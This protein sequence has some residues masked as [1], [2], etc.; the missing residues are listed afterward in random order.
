[1]CACSVADC[2]LSDSTV[3]LHC[4]LDLGKNTGVGCCF[5]LQ[6]IFPNQTSNLSLLFLLHWQADSLPLTT[7]EVPS[8]SGEG[9][10]RHNSQWSWIAGKVSFWG[11]L[12]KKFLTRF[13]ELDLSSVKTEKWIF[14]KKFH[15]MIS[16]P[17]EH[18]HIYKLQ[19]Y[20]FKSS[21]G[22]M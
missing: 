1:M 3:R 2:S 16:F 13:F 10:Q 6:G 19:V 7:W 14:C 20:T 5:L 12:L 9:W 17:K 11:G 15:L 8:G 4:P 21:D 18:H 22:K